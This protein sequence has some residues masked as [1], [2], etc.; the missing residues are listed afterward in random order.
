MRTL[1]SVKPTD[2][3][4]RSSRLVTLRDKVRRLPGGRLLWRI[5]VT[6]V[7]L[8]VIALGLVLIPLPGPGW[9]IVFAGL[10]IWSTEY[11]WARRL[12]TSIRRLAARWWAW[13]ASQTRWLQIVVG[14]LGLAFTAAIVLA[15][16][17]LF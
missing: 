12:T 17:Y 2:A 8:V 7:G 13:I 10:G 11:E 14:V 6:L 15:A 1:E 4:A 9:L 5:G 16:W 3:P